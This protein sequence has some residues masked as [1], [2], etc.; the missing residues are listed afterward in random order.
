MLRTDWI[1]RILCYK[2][3]VLPLFPRLD[4]NPGSFILSQ[5]CFYIYPILYPIL[6]C[7]SIYSRWYPFVLYSQRFK[8]CCAL[9]IV[10]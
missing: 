3:V 2:R 7:T 1:W 8:G 5:Q 4:R 9:R 6:Y 10:Y